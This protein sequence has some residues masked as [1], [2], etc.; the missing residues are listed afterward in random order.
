MYLTL[1]LLP[2]LCPYS[3]GFPQCFNRG[4]AGTNDVTWRCETKLPQQLSLGKT[5]VQCEGY[6]YP[7]DPYVLESSCGLV[8]ELKGNPSHYQHNKRGYWREHH[9]EEPGM[10]GLKSFI[11]FIIVCIVAYNLFCKTGSTNAAPSGA[12][13]HRYGGGDLGGGGYP[14]GVPYQ[15]QNSWGS[16]T[17]WPSNFWTG[18]GLGG[19]LAY[20]FSRRRPTYSRPTFQDTPG[21]Y[22]EKDVMGVEF[23]LPLL[24]CS[25]YNN[26]PNSLQVTGVGLVVVPVHVLLT[27]RIQV[28]PH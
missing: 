13:T 24:F 15:A 28:P 6:D 8:F 4:K 12:N 26:G 7:E 2:I 22:G 11:I 14:D 17:S 10:N 23:H 21:F 9:Y 1:V 3:C 18:M 19:G 27:L 16:G 25:T 20:L 5:V